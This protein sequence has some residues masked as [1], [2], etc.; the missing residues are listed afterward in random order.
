M[1]SLIDSTVFKIPGVAEIDVFLLRLDKARR[2]RALI[3]PILLRVDAELA[4]EVGRMAY[5]SLTGLLDAKTEED[6]MVLFFETAQVRFADG[7]MSSLVKVDAQNELFAGNTD[8]LMSYLDFCVEANFA[9]QLAKLTSV[10]AALHARVQKLQAEKA[11]AEKA[12]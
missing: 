3:H 7:R 9:D 4:G 11:E 10:T 6:L 12:G 8:R 1:A 2:A 5:A